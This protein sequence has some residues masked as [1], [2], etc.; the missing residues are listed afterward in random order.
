MP[1]PTVDPPIPQPVSPIDSRRGRLIK[2]VIRL[3][4]TLHSYFAD[5]NPPLADNGTSL[6]Q[7]THS[8]YSE[9]HPFALAC[10]RMFSF[11]TVDHDT[12][13]L[14]EDLK[15]PDRLQFLD[16]MRK[17]LTD[18]ITRKHWKVVPLKHV[19]AHKTFLPMVWSMKRKRNPLGEI[20][21]WKARLCAG[22]H[23]SIEFV[24]N[25][26]TYSPIVSW[27]TIRL[28]FTLAI[29]NNWH[30]HSIDFVMAFPQA[31]IKT[32]MYMRPPK[33]PHNFHIP[34]IP[35]F[36]DRFTK[37]Y[38][39]IKNLYGLKDASCTWNQHLIAGLLKRSWKQSTIDE[40]LFTKP[41]ILLV[42]YVDD[43]C[44]ISPSQVKIDAE[45]KS[46]QQDY[47]LTDEG[48]LEDYL[49][50][51]FQRNPNGTVTLSMPWIIERA[52]DFVGFNTDN[53]IK[54]HDT[55]AVQILTSAPNA[56]PRA[57]KWHY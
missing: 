49:G 25:W 57:Q 13:N 14:N 18:H 36:T 15:Q 55:L 56:P 31:D 37:V 50:T 48:K 44:I 26:D 32:D 51:R 5:Y 8:N 42:L 10:E 1:Q 38:K 40:C 9:P 7:P 24:D 45:I 53:H 41:G 20:T 46:L 22:G 23:R 27:Q 28:V 54:T 12:M 33:V 34:D 29:V 11:I 30:I 43:A 6:L 21:K 2:P 52:L 47:D 19:P 35:L 17:E 3:G 4:D 16:A 39:L